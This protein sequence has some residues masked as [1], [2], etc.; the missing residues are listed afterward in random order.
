MEPKEFEVWPRGSVC[1]QLR[2]SSAPPAPRPYSRPRPPASRP[3][4]HLLGPCPPNRGPPEHLLQLGRPK[5]G[6]ARPPCTDPPEHLLEPVPPYVGHRPRLVKATNPNWEGL[7]QREPRSA[8]PIG[9]QPRASSAPPPPSPSRDRPTFSKASMLRSTSAAPPKASTGATSATCQRP[10][11][12]KWSQRWSVGRPPALTLSAIGTTSEST[13]QLYLEAMAIADG[14]KQELQNAGK[15]VP[16]TPGP[17]PSTAEGVPKAAAFPRVF[18]HPRG[19]RRL[20][21][22]RHLRRLRGIRRRLRAVRHRAV[23][24]PRCF[25]RRLLFSGGVG[26]A[27]AVIYPIVGSGTA[28]GH[29]AAVI[30]PSVGSGSV[31]LSAP[32]RASS[33]AVAGIRGLAPFRASDPWLALHSMP[34]M[35]LIPT[36]MLIGHGLRPLD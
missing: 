8:L 13:S 14:L 33:L 25:R 29:A 5:H 3:P 6:P 16:R 15:P 9:L 35:A 19:I 31:L 17:V 2:S 7:W 12:P 1:A 11:R 22:V 26:H 28:V 20:R 18:H 27:A 24:H 4:R 32:L 34:P 10:L 36:T 30:Y 21:A 23:R